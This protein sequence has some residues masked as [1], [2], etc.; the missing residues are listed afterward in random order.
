[1]QR[2]RKNIFELCYTSEHFRTRVLFSKRDWA[3]AV[4]ESSGRTRATSAISSTFH[5]VPKLI[6]C[7]VATNIFFAHSALR[8]S[9]NAS[10]SSVIF[11]E[12]CD[13][14]RRR[15]KISTSR[16]S[17]TKEKLEIPLWDNPSSL[18]SIFIRN[19]ITFRT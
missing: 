14:E 8:I 5:V 15:I 13:K 9:D 6:R 18:F 4:I 2:A 12:S 10:Q 19:V 17:K 16:R 11:T 1:M 7:T 3:D